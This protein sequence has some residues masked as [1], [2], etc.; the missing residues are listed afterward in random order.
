MGPVLIESGSR[1]YRIEVNAVAADG[2]WNADV[3]L[4]RLFSHE[5]P[6]VELVSCDKLSAEHAEHAAVIW[7]RRWVD[8]TADATR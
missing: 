2:R 8:L 1:G 5:K 6:H 7:A 3:R 4:R